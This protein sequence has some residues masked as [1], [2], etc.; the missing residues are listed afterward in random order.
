MVLERFVPLMQMSSGRRISILNQMRRLAQD[1]SLPTLVA[2]IDRALAH[3][4]VTRDYDNRW[5]E[6]SR[7]S[8]YSPAV[9][10]LDRFADIGLASIR[11]VT[12]AQIRGL[13]Q[14]DPLVID[15]NAMLEDIFPAGVGAVTSLPFID[16]VAACEVIVAKLT[17]RWASTVSQLGLQQRVAYLSEYTQQYREAV[18]ERRNLD[19]ATVQ[20]YRRRGQQML[21]E[22]VV[23]TLGL[24][25]DSENPDQVR[26]R[27]R[28]LEPLVVQLDDI[29]A[30]NRARRSRADNDQFDGDGAPVEGEEMAPL[31]DP[32]EGPIAGPEEG[33]VEDPAPLPGELPDGV[34]SGPEPGPEPVAV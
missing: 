6:P 10:S 19:F 34:P 11:D 31:E 20:Q 4:T 27:V 15:A 16:E 32:E 22:V 33:T 25:A 14:S 23:T 28:L 2:H 5:V 24:F 17:G 21:R 9:M 8:L 18:D 13:P 30:R 1:A 29:R 7:R 12:V 3:D 26:A